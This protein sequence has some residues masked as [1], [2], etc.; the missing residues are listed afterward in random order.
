[1]RKG[2]KMKQESLE[3]EY[4]DEDNDEDRRRI[5]ETAEMCEKR[6]NQM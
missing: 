6:A 1:M 3:A 5:D 4:E 2:V